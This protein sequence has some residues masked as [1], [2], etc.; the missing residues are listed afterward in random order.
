MHEQ[1]RGFTLI[2]TMIAVV[3]IGIVLSAGLPAF[4]TYRTTMVKRQAREQL[5]QDLR[6][7]RQTA[8]TQHKQV[9]V[10]F[11]DGVGTT[12]ITT[13]TIHHD[14]N[15]DKVYQNSER[16]FQRTMPKDTRLAKVSLTPVDSLLFDTSGI[17]RPGT[18][19]GWMSMRTNTGFRDTVSV[20]IAGMVY[21]Q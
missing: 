18:S 5:L 16:R 21:R 9:I 6:G 11:G 8:I 13:Y 19:G 17:L 3:V 7:A 2:E 4:A 15:N 10:A 12:D 1:Q 20:S 14:T